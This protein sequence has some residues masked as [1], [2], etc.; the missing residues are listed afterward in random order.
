MFHSLHAPELERHHADLAKGLSGIL[1][2][3]ADPVSKETAQDYLG[4]F[5]AVLQ[6]PVITD[7]HAEE[8]FERHTQLS[9][10]L[11]HHAD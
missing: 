7:A 2:S 4:K 6:E 8:L 9:A 3:L 1:L 5:M 10:A 11:D